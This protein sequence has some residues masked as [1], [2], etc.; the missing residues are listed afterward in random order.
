MDAT[1]KTLDLS[2][3]WAYKGQV[4]KNK[5]RYG[6]GKEAWEKDDTQHY[7]GYYNLNCLHGNGEY[8]WGSDSCYEG[9]FYGN[10]ING[11]GCMSYKDG[12]YFEGLFKENQRF[13]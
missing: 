10:N 2:K 12:S 13:V 3:F 9:S 6:F 11:Y 5:I 8:S 4:N 7:Q 1:V